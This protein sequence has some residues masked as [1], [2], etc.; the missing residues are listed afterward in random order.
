MLIQYFNLHKIKHQSNYDSYVPLGKA[1]DGLN[2]L[3]LKR[4]SN[5]GSRFHSTGSKTTFLLQTLS[6]EFTVSAPSLTMGLPTLSNH[7]E[8]PK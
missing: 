2:H 6:G 4:H 8:L 3:V 1:Q 5:L 7:T